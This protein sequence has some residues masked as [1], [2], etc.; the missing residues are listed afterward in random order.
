M[1]GPWYKVTLVTVAL[2][3][4]VTVRDVHGQGDSEEGKRK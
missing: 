4:T 1:G 3:L 2:I